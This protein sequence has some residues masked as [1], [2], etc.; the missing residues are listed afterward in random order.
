[1]DLFIQPCLIEEDLTTAAVIKKGDH[2]RDN[3][4]LDGFHDFPPRNNNQL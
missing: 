2:F 4:Q 1:M 3:F